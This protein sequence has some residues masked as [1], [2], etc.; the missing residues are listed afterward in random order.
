MNSRVMFRGGLLGRAPA[1]VPAG[2]LAAL[3][4]AVMAGCGS[5]APDEGGARSAAPLT[6]PAA[7][8]SGA[9]GSEAEGTDR[10]SGTG[11]PVERPV[12]LPPG[13]PGLDAPEMAD[14]GPSRPEP[15]GQEE[16][17]RT[18]PVE[19]LL[20]AETV[21][22]VMG[23]RWATHPGSAVECA[24]P[25]DALGVRTRAYESGRDRV[26]QIL[27]THH[28]PA[29]ADTAVSG[30]ADQLARCGWSVG[31]DPRIGSASVTAEDG[32]G[33]V[34]TAVSV[35]GVGVVLVGSAGTA[36]HRGRWSAL[37][38]MALGSSCPAAPDG[39]H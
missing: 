4:V 22:T 29:D 26:L 38:D 15:H 21:G 36:R 25:G 9:A 3:L 30:L 32:T 34:L 2:V 16:A 7:T 20:D 8:A 19:A 33:R 24:V 10:P 39:C 12:S 28:D 5:E 35:E 27:T 18:V 11:G 37:V 31:P 6:T 1:V 17:L 13:D 23:G 14:P